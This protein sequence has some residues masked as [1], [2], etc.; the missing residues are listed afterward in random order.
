MSGPDFK[1]YSSLNWRDRAK[2]RKRRAEELNDTLAAYHSCY[3]RVREADLALSPYGVRLVPNDRVFH[4]YEDWPGLDRRKVSGSVRDGR[5]LI[6]RR[7]EADRPLCRYCS[8]RW[9][10][11]TDGSRIWWLLPEGQSACVHCRGC[12][13]PGNLSLGPKLRC[14]HSSWKSARQM[15]A[16]SKPRHHRIHFGIGVAWEKDGGVL[17][18]MEGRDRGAPVPLCRQQHALTGRSSEKR[19]YLVERGVTIRGP[20]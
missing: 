13:A 15:V 4:I 18:F 2:E 7:P 20:L 17:Q 14:A 19:S 12:K 11:R 10:P 5:K 6:W 8:T 1:R 3:W 16:A 9:E